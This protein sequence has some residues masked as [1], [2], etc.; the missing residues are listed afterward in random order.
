MSFAQTIIE[1]TV[2]DVHGKAVDAYVMV[3]SKGTGIIIASAGTNVKGEYKFVIHSKADSLTVTAA[4]INIGQ[5]AKII[6]NRSQRLNFSVK[7]QSVKLKEVAVRAQKIRQSG[8]TLNYLVGAYQQQ[9]D[10]VIADVL[11]RM[12]G[13][14]VSD[15]GGIKYNGKAIK[16]FYVEEMDLLHGRYGLATNNINASDVAAVHVLENH[17][18]VKALQ[19]KTL[20]DDVA[21]NL[22]LKNSAKG[23]L[24]VNTALGIGIQQSGDWGFGSCQ[25]DDGQSIVGKNPL[26]TAEV[27]GMYFAKRRQNIAL[28]KGNNTG[29]DVSKELTQHYS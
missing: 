28:Y 2:L 3:S 10:H 6:A 17:Q 16:K 12:P 14:E 15:N 23:T 25:L 24:A 9:G 22:K 19:G 29:N 21:I 20:T 1:G 8:D 18:P 5:M 7:E 4:G 11:K 27:V 13:I 26:W